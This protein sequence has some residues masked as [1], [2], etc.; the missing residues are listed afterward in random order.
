MKEKKVVHH[1]PLPYLG[2]RIMKTSLAVF[3]CLAIHGILGFEGMAIESAIAA[4]V[5]MQPQIEDTKKYA[6]DRIVGTVLG[7]G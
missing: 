5:C 4:I 2:H 1:F 3:L 7:A 6:L